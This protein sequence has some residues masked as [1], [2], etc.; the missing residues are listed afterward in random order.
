VGAGAVT[1]TTTAMVEDHGEGVAAAMEEAARVAT[2]DGSAHP[3]T[4]GA[5]QCPQAPTRDGTCRYNKYVY[6]DYGLIKL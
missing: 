5:A 6:D 4:Y 3:H 2:G 1:T